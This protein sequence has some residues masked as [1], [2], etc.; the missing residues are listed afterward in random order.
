MKIINKHSHFLFLH[1]GFYRHFSW[2]IISS[3]IGSIL[4]I[5]KAAF[6]KTKVS[7]KIHLLQVEKITNRQLVLLIPT[8]NLTKGLLFIGFKNNQLSV[9]KFGSGDFGKLDL[10]KIIENLDRINDNHLV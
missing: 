10:I 7:S 5:F 8:I 3:F 4:M 2:L 9:A 6:S 1:I